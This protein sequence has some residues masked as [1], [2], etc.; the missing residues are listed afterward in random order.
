MSSLLIGYCYLAKEQHGILTD[1]SA[2]S[3]YRFPCKFSVFTLNL[4]F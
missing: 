1:N 4:S 3:P 2:S